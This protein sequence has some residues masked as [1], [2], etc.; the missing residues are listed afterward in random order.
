M[1]DKIEKRLADTN[2]VLMGHGVGVA[3]LEAMFN[4][5]NSQS[6]LSATMVRDHE[7]SHPI[8]MQAL[9]QAL[10][11]LLATS[12]AMNTHRVTVARTQA[13]VAPV[14]VDIPP[15]TAQAAEP[16]VKPAGQSSVDLGAVSDLSAL[17]GIKKG[18]GDGRG[19]DGAGQQS[20]L[21]L[22]SMASHTGLDG[23][24]FQQLLIQFMT[25]ASK[26]MATVLENSR[27]HLEVT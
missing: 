23:E 1:A 5:V 13:P 27:P 19:L 8:Q 3:A 16:P 22:D 10:A 24:M 26:H 2:A 17:D 21:S 15:Q 9:A 11:Q 20:S 25:M 6:V 4:L 7:L 12:E 14:A 18:A